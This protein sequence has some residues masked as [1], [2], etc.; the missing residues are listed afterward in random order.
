MIGF[1]AYRVSVKSAS[2]KEALNLALINKVKYIDTSSNYTNGDSEKLIGKCLKESSYKPF[3]ISKVGYVQGDN[4][5]IVKDNNLS[6]DLVELNEHLKHSIHPDFLEDQLKR[7]LERL[8]IDTLDC[9]LLHNPEY[10]LK[11]SDSNKDEYYKRIEKALIKFEDFVSRGLI[12]SYGI[13]SNTF[14]DPKDDHES[15]NLEVIIDI[16]K[17]NKLTGFK[18]IQ[19]PMNL[20]EL[21]SIERQFGGKHLIE[22]AKEHSIH[23]MINRPFNAFTAQGFV[24]LCE[25]DTKEF[26]KDFADKEFV[27]LTQSAV[28]E[29]SFQSDDEKERLEELPL[30]SQIKKIWYKQVSTDAVEQIFYGHFFPLLTSVWGRSLTKE[31]AAPFFDLFDLAIEAA[32]FNMT[33]RAKEFKSI[34]ISQG[35]IKD[36]QLS[37]QQIAVKKYIDLGV[38]IVLCGMKD[39]KYVKELT[40]YF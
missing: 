36:S 19:F 2:H 13:S 6:T 29:W 25:Y 22:L 20:L 5:Q 39:K 24:R 16:I 1:G 32:R 15:T 4:L 31:E 23:T 37:I 17:R 14:I 8:G 3:I 12:K 33:K 9:Y 21:G 7:S 38:D 27:K 10:Y 30:F 40:P 18:Y 34:A 28:D 11:L 35:L 26:N